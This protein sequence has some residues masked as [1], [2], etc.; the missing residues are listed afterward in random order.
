MGKYAEEGLDTVT[1]LALADQLGIERIPAL[2]VWISGVTCRAV[3]EAQV[4][5]VMVTEYLPFVFIVTDEI[6]PLVVMVKAGGM[7]GQCLR[8]YCAVKKGVGVHHRLT[9]V[10]VLAGKWCGCYN[11]RRI[12][13]KP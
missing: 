1:G 10:A 9:P 2:I 6:A 5:G 4:V 13:C 7:A 3:R 12:V 8:G 11:R